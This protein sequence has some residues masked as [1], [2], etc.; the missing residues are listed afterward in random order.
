MKTMKAI[1]TATILALV[2]TVPAYAGD[3]S[4]PG[5]SCEGEIG[6]PGT[7]APGDVASQSTLL[8]D[9]GS[10]GLMDILW[11]VFTLV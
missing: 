11:T 1:C 8:G 3:I 4:T 5:V 6:C 9:I 2:L 7:T 10:P